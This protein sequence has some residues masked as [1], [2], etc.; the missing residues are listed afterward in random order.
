MD[1]TPICEVTIERYR[2]DWVAGVV[3]LFDDHGRFFAQFD[4]GKQSRKERLRVPI[5]ARFSA[6]ILTY[7]PNEEGSDY[8]ES[9]FT[10]RATG[11]EDDVA[12]AW[13]GPG[14]A[15]EGER[16][17]PHPVGLE[18]GVRAVGAVLDAVEVV[19]EPEVLPFGART[20][21]DVD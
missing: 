11:E 1:T 20:F 10:F 9:V 8:Y 6:R 17:R 12:V 2:T 13:T 4:T 14:L 19:A 15:S 5:G 7:T 16:L 18:D 3:F 21:R